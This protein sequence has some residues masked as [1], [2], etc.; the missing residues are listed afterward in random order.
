MRISVV[1]PDD[2]GHELERCKRQERAT[3][4]EIVRH[5]LGVY[6]EDHR[7]RLAGE[8]LLRAAAEAPLSR[9]QMRRALRQLEAERA[10][11]DRA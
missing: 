11:S 9:D 4:S 2:L 5:A 1:L 3:T 8:A 7:R 10:R 6:L